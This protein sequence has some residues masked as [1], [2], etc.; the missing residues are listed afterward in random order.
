MMRSSEST[1]RDSLA[2]LGIDFGKEKRRQTEK[3]K[4][5]LNKDESKADE[6]E[7]RRRLIESKPN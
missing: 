5:H 1:E 3:G 6:H 2:P 7:E 4:Y